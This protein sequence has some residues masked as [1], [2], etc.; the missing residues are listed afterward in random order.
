MSQTLSAERYVAG[1]MTDEEAASF[2]EIMLSEP[3]VAADVEFRHR[4]KAGLGWLET[5][6]ELP[7]ML[8]G[9]P[10]RRFLPYA[11][12]ATV[13]AALIAGGTILSQQAVETMA[14]R[15]SSQSFRLVNK[16]SGETPVLDIAAGTERVTL[17]VPVDGD[18]HALYS[19]RIQPAAGS[20][21]PFVPQSV[22]LAGDGMV[23]IVIDGTEIP[24]GSY[25]VLLTANDGT[26]Q[27][28]PFTV[29][30]TH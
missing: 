8:E 27:S 20:G 18:E 22:T 3:A 11:T 7:N 19:A 10:S 21:T 28:L 6:G 16:R 9:A 25:T 1:R 14:H 15:D 13:L 23:E 29:S 4:I 12:A 5:K 24:A 17:R 30:T 2:E 26:T